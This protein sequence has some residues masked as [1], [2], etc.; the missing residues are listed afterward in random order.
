MYRC[1]VL[2]CTNPYL[3]VHCTGAPCYTYS[4]TYLYRCTVLYLPLPVQVHLVI[5]TPTCTLY[6]VQGHRV[7][8][9]PTCTV[10]TVQG[11][12]VILTL[13]VQVHREQ[14]PTRHVSPMLRVAPLVLSVHWPQTVQQPRGSWRRCSCGQEGGS[15]GQAVVS[16]SRDTWQV[17]LRWNLD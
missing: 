13:P 1:T 12:H 16:C 17:K 8:Q 2:Y 6:S 7:I 4:N 14:L 15:G 9:T 10:Y 5:L 3:Y 11:H